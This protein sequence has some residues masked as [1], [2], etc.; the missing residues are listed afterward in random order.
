MVSQAY[1]NLL[2]IFESFENRRPYDRIKKTLIVLLAVFFII[3]LTVVIAG[4]CGVKPPD[5]Q[6]GYK[7]GYRDSYQ[8]AFE[9]KHYNVK[10]GLNESRIYSDGYR[11]GYDEG[12]PDGQIDRVIYQERAAAHEYEVSQSSKTSQNNETSLSHETDNDNET[13][14][15]NQTSLISRPSQPRKINYQSDD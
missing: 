10:D 12:Y 14:R 4:F 2:R 8:T 5:Y 3:G 6:Q 1:K 9:G 11:N 13:I 7:D 15:D